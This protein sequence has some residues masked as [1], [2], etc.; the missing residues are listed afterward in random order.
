[1]FLQ[2]IKIIANKTGTHKMKV[3][4]WNQKT[5]NSREIEMADELATHAIAHKLTITGLGA[6]SPFNKNKRV[7]KAVESSEEEPVKKSKKSKE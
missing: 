4:H 6:E 3:L 5:G 2:L 1:L 7:K